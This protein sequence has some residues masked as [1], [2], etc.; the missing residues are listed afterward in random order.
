MIDSV[1]VDIDLDGLPELL[2]EGVDKHWTSFK[3]ALA[4]E[5]T[6][7]PSD[8]EFL[9]N[10]CRVWAASEFVALRCAR[11]P[12]LLLGLLDSGDLN[13]SYNADTYSRSL[14]QQIQ[15]E[16]TDTENLGQC[17][18]R[19][20][21]RE[22]L[23][24]AWRDILGLA[25]VNETMSDLSALADACIQLA[26]SWLHQQMTVELGIP[27]S[28]VSQNNEG[29]PQ[30]MVVLGMGKLGA[31][32]LNFSSDVDLIFVFPETGE[33]HGGQRSMS[34]EQFFARLGQSLIKA[35]DEN[36]AE[37]FVFR[38][39]MRLRPFGQSGALA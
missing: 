25:D 6:A 38:V 32:E 3:E 17:L 19:F 11:Q 9:E 30:Q 14:G 18:R 8:A 39:D 33:T 1:S 27:H 2:R 36:T 24:I 35:L 16:V 22:M 13:R 23:R 37:G 12:M 10:L 34:N 5:G 4:R 7:V 28:N 29:Q 31:C 21:Q 15:A 26:L 20:R